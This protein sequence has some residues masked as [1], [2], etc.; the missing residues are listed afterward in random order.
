MTPGGLQRFELSKKGAGFGLSK[1][2]PFAFISCFYFLLFPIF[3]FSYSLML[4]ALI[5]YFY[6][7]YSISI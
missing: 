3:I 7:I 1:T 4:F 2:R 6:L 5:P